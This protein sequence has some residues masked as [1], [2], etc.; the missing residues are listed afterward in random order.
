MAAVSSRP[1]RWRPCETAPVEETAECT[2]AAMERIPME[3]DLRESEAKYRSLYSNAA[4]AVP[5]VINLHSRA[6]RDL[7][8]AS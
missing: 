8:P 6:S 7:I 2:W 1:R 3:S 4:A 5:F